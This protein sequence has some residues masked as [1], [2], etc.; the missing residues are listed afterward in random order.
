MPR[1]ILTALFLVIALGSGT[2][3]ARVSTPVA[4]P[5]TNDATPTGLTGDA[6]A[7]LVGPGLALLPL[8]EPDTATVVLTGP[9][10]FQHGTHIPFVIQNRTGETVTNIGVAAS[11]Y[12]D[13]N[14]LIGTGQAGQALI[15]PVVVAPGG[16]AIGTVGFGT[17]RLAEAVRFAFEVDWVAGT[18]ADPFYDL[19]IASASFEGDRIVG[20]VRNQLGR[21]VTYYASV[22]YA[23][24]SQDG[25]LLHVETVFT[26]AKSIDPGETVP[27]LIDEHAIGDPCKLFVLTAAGFS[28][29]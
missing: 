4:N 3:S 2:A 18:S 5:A 11:A 16:Y 22:M 15:Q 23:C 9:Y 27:F 13:D 29:G 20:E 28:P 19:S 14:E 25:D 8:G 1:R 7:E 6:T 26:D 21:P 12:A 10:I 24:L 17:P